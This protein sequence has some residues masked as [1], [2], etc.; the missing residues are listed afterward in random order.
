MQGLILGKKRR[1]HYVNVCTI[2]AQTIVSHFYGFVQILKYQDEMDD[3]FLFV[4]CDQYFFV[5]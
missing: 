3:L 1:F 2:T 4:L 5:S